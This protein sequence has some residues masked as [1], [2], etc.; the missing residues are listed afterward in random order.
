MQ[1]TDTTLIDQNIVKESGCRLLRRVLCKRRRSI[2]LI[3]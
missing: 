2:V 1:Q 3:E